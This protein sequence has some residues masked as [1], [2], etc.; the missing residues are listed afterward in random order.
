[1]YIGIASHH[2]YTYAYIGR[3]RL[4]VDGHG[5]ERELLLLRLDEL[6]LELAALATHLG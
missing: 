3:A 1:M 4:L 2:T 5:A 6:E